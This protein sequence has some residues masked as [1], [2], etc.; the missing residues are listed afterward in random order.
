MPAD[1]KPTV[2]IA[3]VQAALAELK[4][5]QQAGSPP[6]DFSP[7]LRQ[8]VESFHDAV[9][10]GASALEKGLEQAV[11]TQKTALQ[12]AQIGTMQAHAVAVASWL[13]SEGHIKHMCLHGHAADIAIRMARMYGYR[14]KEVSSHYDAQT[15][16]RE[17]IDALRVLTAGLEHESVAKCAPFRKRSGWPGRDPNDFLRS[18][19]HTR[20]KLETRLCAGHSLDATRYTLC[21]RQ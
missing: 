16:A 4:H 12:T 8:Q 2:N 7:E 9:Q 19:T 18:V 20:A 17:A 14:V 5:I 15:Q 10:R 6:I 11:Q 21:I 13:A 3:E 1:S